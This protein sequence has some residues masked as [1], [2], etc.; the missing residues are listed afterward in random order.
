M[1]LA[2]EL[3]GTPTIVTLCADI[4]RKSAPTNESILPRP[5]LHL[6]HGTK[7]GQYE[8]QGEKGD[9]RAP[10]IRT[11]L[12]YFGG[13]GINRS[14]LRSPSCLAQSKGVPSGVRPH[15]ARSRQSRRRQIVL[16]PPAEKPRGFTP[17]FVACAQFDAQEAHCPPFR[18]A[19]S[20]SLVAH[21]TV[22]RKVPNWAADRARRLPEFKSVIDRI[23]TNRYVLGSCG[24]SKATPIED[25]TSTHCLAGNPRPRHRA[26]PRGPDAPGPRREG[27]RALVGFKMVLTRQ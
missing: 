14:L 6:G 25:Q 11:R 1:A 2:R 21:G 17:P 15:G 16:R 24:C 9:S 18:L 7:L 23:P 26:C 10:K 27:A 19:M 12:F 22:R 4:R 5:G 8:P 20:A 13:A 3:V